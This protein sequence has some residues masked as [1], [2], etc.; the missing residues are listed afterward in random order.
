MPKINGKNIYFNA[1][2]EA[3]VNRYASVLIFLGSIILKKAHPQI[4]RCAELHLAAISRSKE[5]AFVFFLHDQK[6]DRAYDYS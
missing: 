6:S 3:L 2:K 4:S 5:A 1:K